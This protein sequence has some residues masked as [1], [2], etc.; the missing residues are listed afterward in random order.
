MFVFA[1]WP[2]AI[3]VGILIAAAATIAVFG[4]WMTRLAD[5]LAGV[6]GIGEA[7]MG[8]IILGGS[9]S[10]P[11]ITTSV[12]AGVEGRVVSGCFPGLLLHI[13]RLDIHKLLD[14][15]VRQLPA[16]AALLDAAERQA[17]I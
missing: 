3:S 14:A 7:L 17:R 16:I 10:L 6:T 1:E 9:T 12:T 15:V 8:A 4:S 11:G 5:E 13:N 2:L